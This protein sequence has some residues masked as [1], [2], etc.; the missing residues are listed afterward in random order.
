[1]KQMKITPANAGRIEAAL[2]AANGRAWVHT[3]NHSFEI[4]NLADR[5]EGALSSLR[6]PRSLRVGA[7]ATF[8]SG[9]P[10][11]NAYKWSRIVTQVV[12]LRRA[13]GWFLCEVRRGTAYNTMTSSDS[14]RMRITSEQSEEAYGR[15]LEAGNLSVTGRN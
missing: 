8:T 1:M 4:A 11:P 3:Y 13:T 15:F 12:M 5:A 10:L 7:E 2:S 6:L 14:Y 9:A